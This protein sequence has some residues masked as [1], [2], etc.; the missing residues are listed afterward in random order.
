MRRLDS[1]FHVEGD[2]IV[3]TSN[4]GILPENEPLFLAKAV[5]QKFNCKSEQIG[6]PVRIAE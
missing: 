5:I 3:K 6:Y 4:G 1:K 2:Q